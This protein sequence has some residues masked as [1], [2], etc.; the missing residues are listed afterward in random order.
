MK[1]TGVGKAGTAGG[2]ASISLTTE[3]HL[4]QQIPAFNQQV[5]LLH[6][7][8]ATPL[9]TNHQK[10]AARGPPVFSQLEGLTRGCKL[11]MEQGQELQL[12]TRRARL[13]GRA[14]LRPRQPLRREAASRPGDGA[15]AAENSGSAAQ[16]G[17]NAE[18]LRREV[19]TGNQEDLK[20]ELGT[21]II[22]TTK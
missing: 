7:L 14:D 19:N 8:H 4:A 3:G 15:L 22:F 17:Q 1:R 5:R 20:E 6:S 21:P 12:T 10:E 18:L 16:A 13:Q 9:H 11:K 2:R